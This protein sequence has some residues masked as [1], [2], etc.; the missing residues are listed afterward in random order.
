MK[1]H[2]FPPTGPADAAS[3]A[4]EWVVLNGSDD[5]DRA[6]IETQSRFDDAVKAMV[7]TPPTRSEHAHFDAAI[8]VIRW[9]KWM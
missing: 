7:S 6:W 3:A 8:L 1:T 2:S 5:A 4:L 9:R